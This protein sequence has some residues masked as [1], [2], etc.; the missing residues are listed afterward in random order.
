MGNSN[1]PMGSIFDAADEGGVD[2]D[3]GFVPSPH[4]PIHS[5]LRSGIDWD[6][7]RFPRG[8]SS[9]QEQALD[10]PRLVSATA[11]PPTEEF[12]C[13]RVGPCRHYAEWLSEHDSAGDHVLTAV[14]GM[15]CGFS[16]LVPLTEDTRFACTRYSPPWWS[17]RGLRRRII[18][19][20]RI[21][22]AQRGLA[23]RA[24]LTLAEQVAEAIYNAVK[25]DAPELPRDPKRG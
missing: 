11:L 1:N 21:G 5:A 17:L 20:H 7:A 2:G 15:C 4:D 8:D 13:C 24:Q 3:D 19:V 22:R 14:S 10:G 25:G 18:S 16:E 12:F 6:Q 23:G 9:A